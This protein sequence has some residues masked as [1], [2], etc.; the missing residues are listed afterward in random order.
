MRFIAQ[1]LWIAGKLF[2]YSSILLMPVIGIPAAWYVDE[3]IRP[4]GLSLLGWDLCT[5]TLALAVLGELA[6]TGFIILL[7]AALIRAADW[8]KV[9]TSN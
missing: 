3:N 1:R 5:F 7:M 2:L 9:R 4:F 8:L 6:A